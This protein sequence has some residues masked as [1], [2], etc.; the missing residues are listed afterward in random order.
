[1]KKEPG[2]N[3][4]WILASES[5][6]RREILD[7]LGIRFSVDPSGICEP[8]AKPGE[9]PSRYA[10]RIARLKAKE[11]TKRHKSGFILSA[12]TIVVLRN[13]ILLKP[14]NRGDAHGMGQDG[15]QSVQP[16]LYGADTP[17]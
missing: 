9:T 5:P 12:D 14:E 10:V 13:R 16:F 8:A 3:P 6:R 15:F 17:W 1:M 11:V 7:R 4:K 2:K